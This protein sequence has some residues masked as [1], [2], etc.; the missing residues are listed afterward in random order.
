MERIK[1]RDIAKFVSLII[2]VVA[3]LIVAIYFNLQGIIEPDKIQEEINSYGSVAPI[4]YILIFVISLI[5]FFPITIIIV[6]GAILFGS[7]Y[8]S[9]YS[10]IGALIGAII[11]FY[12]ARLLGKRFVD[13]ITEIKFKRI[14]KYNHQIA[15]NGFAATFVARISPIL[16]YS[17]LSYF[18][19][20]TRVKFWDYFLGSFFGISI[21]IIIVTYLSDSLVSLRLVD[22]IISGILFLLLLFILPIH[23]YL[24]KYIRYLKNKPKKEK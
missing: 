10:I 23:H 18:F 11:A 14:K 22:I 6:L 17:G 2:L 20:L 19:G 15:K 8:G 3:F 16:H 24:K 5:T 12:I 9:I 13:I 21:W 1:K 7:F 4:A